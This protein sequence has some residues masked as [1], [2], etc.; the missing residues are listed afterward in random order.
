MINECI[1]I[2]QYPLWKY[3]GLNIILLEG[4]GKDWF[5]IKHPLITSVSQFQRLSSPLNLSLLP[6]IS[7]KHHSPSKLRSKPKFERLSHIY[8]VIMYENVDAKVYF[9]WCGAIKITKKLSHQENCMTRLIFNNHDMFIFKSIHVH[10]RLKKLHIIRIEGWLC[11][12]HIHLQSK[13]ERLACQ[14]IIITWPMV[15]TSALKCSIE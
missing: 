12:L 4:R 9:V 5:V 1:Y 8:Y 15:L 3:L 6:P 14:N 13:G 11:T 2:C 7:S 10:W